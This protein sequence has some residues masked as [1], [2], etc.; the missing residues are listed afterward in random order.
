MSFLTDPEIGSLHVDRMII[1][2]VGKRIDFQRAPETPVQQQEFFQS[3]IIDHAASAVHRFTEHSNVRPV[4]QQMGAEDIDFEAGG[5]ELARLFWHDHPTQSTPGAFF[6][7]QLSTE[8]EGDILYALIKY[9]YRA[10]VELS[11]RDGHNVL[12]EIIQAFVKEKRAV[13][14]FCMARYRDGTIEDM[15]SATDRMAEAPDLTDYFEN[16]LGVSRARSTTELSAR[17]NEAMRSTLNEVRDSLPNRNVGQALARAKQALRARGVVSN[18]DVV[19]ALLHGAGRPADEETIARFGRVARGK[20]KRCNLTD[21]EF[22]P[23]P[24]AL[25]VAPRHKVKTAE[26]T[27]LEYD[28]AQ[29]GRT[30]FREDTEQGAVFTVRTE[31]RLVEDDT[32]KIRPS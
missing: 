31:N 5:Q 17:L 30:V 8:I 32:V 19:D 11:Q 27:R 10:V 1:H 12:R 26:G 21:V 25:Q 22:R 3:R 23:D 16:Y 6:V 20:L 2:L 4:L 13:Q 7:F 18:D 29:L 14:K 28:E 15:V 9:D 24:D